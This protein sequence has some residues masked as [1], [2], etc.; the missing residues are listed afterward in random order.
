LNGQ[1][2]GCSL[3]IV[4]DRRNRFHFSG[5]QNR[6]PDK[7]SW[8]R[9][10]F[11][12]NR[13]FFG[14]AR[15]VPMWTIFSMDAEESAEFPVRTSLFRSGGWKEFKL[16]IRSSS[17]KRS[18]IWQHRELRKIRVLFDAACQIRHFLHEDRNA[19]RKETPHKCG[20]NSGGGLYCF[21]IGFKLRISILAK[22]ML[23][24]LRTLSLSSHGY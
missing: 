10:S 16:I 1:S 5:E 9:P 23:A 22:A 13:P 2:T 19:K 18:E 20:K 12:D 15:N 21:G 17:G 3:G 14:A 11:L 6:S 8:S 7:K 4:A 24:K